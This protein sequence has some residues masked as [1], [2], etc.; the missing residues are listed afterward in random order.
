M[1]LG[2]WASLMTG[3]GPRRV[4]AGAWDAGDAEP[5]PG[6][7]T[8]SPWSRPDYTW[9]SVRVLQVSPLPFS[10]SAHGLPR[11]TFYFGTWGGAVSREPAS[12]LNWE[13]FLLEAGTPL[14]SSPS[15]SLF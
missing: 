6:G 7:L 5:H 15:C 4:P 3:K 10:E 1:T 2:P 11:K 8:A 14:L 12:S 9:P 13:V